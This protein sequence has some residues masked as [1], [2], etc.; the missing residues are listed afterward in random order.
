MWDNGDKGN[1]FTVTLDCQ[2]RTFE[3]RTENQW[4]GKMSYPSSW[5]TVFAAVGGQSS[6]HVMVIG[7]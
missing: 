4:L 3:V 7:D 6:H 1:R 2:A 5:T